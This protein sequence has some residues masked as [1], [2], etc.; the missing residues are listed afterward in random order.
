[1]Q[2]LATVLTLVALLCGCR[3]DKPLE[4]AKKNSIEGEWTATVVGKKTKAFMV[5]AFTA[6]DKFTAKLR[7]P[8]D[9]GVL[10]WVG[11]YKLAGNQLTM[12]ATDVSFEVTNHQ[13][14]DEVKAGLPAH[15]DK[16]LKDFNHDPTGTVKWVDDNKF[17][18]TSGPNNE[19]ATFTRN[20]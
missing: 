10:I 1:M 19:L 5:V 3:N 12:R 14:G 16:V 6:P 9:G 20:Q 13:K 11:N 2:R 15:K 7:L 17:T 18:V 4:G 8:I